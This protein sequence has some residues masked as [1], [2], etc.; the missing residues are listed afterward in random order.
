M[1]LGGY[2]GAAGDRVADVRDRN[3]VHFLYELGSKDI[4]RG[5]LGDEPA[6]V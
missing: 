4:P 6:L 2:D 1:G 5:A 3:M